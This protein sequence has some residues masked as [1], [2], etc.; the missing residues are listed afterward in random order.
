MDRKKLPAVLCLAAAVLL[1]AYPAAGR[2][3][4]RRTHS[5]VICAQ[6]ESVG[7]ADP[8]AVAEALEAA[9]RYN[10]TLAS[11]LAGI[12]WDG[13]NE[14]ETGY[15]SLLNLAGDGVMGIV[16]IPVLGTE[17]PIAHGTDA[18]T[19]E[20]YVGHVPGSSLPVGGQNTH[21]V[22]S[23]HSGMA[24]S[25]M[26][27][28]LEKLRPGDCFVI[29]VLGQ[30]LCYRIDQIETVLPDDTSGL[31]IERG[32]DY[33]TLV[34]CTP[35]GVNTH[36]LLVRGVRIPKEEMP[37]LPAETT[38]GRT[39]WIRTAVFIA[40]G[41]CAVSLTAFLIIRRRRTER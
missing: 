26:F 36:R 30:E 29:R 38:A 41:V 1:A 33:V 17:L 22:L 31:G 21:A 3:L 5:E 34:T 2:L 18:R 28:D 32:K 8:L 24:A 11:G 25:R 12:T 16:E 19:L 40:A 15:D 14:A 13:R 4:S 37:A 10:A 35:C 27:S 9:D 6:A 23:G 20:H 7:R 39:A